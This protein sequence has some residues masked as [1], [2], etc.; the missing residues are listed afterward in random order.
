M[1]KRLGC[2]VDLVENGREAV[3]ARQKDASYDLVFL[4]CHMPEMDGLEASRALRKLGL[5]LPAVAM[6]ASTLSGERERCLAAG[7]DDYLTQPLR[8][9]ELSAKLQRWLERRPRAA[10]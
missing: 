4:D 7:M 8:M 2:R 1:L 9:V 5:V 10:C 3:E 6:T